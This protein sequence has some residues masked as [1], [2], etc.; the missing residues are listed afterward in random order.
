MIGYLLNGLGVVKRSRD[1]EVNDRGWNPHKSLDSWLIN[2]NY[3]PFK[4]ALN[5]HRFS[6]PF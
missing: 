1:G 2:C 6:S 4:T 5:F 3:S